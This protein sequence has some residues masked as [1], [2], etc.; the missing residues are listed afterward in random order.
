M[1]EVASL[2]IRT[3]ALRVEGPAELGLVLGVPAEGAELGHA[4]RKLALLAVFARA[5]LFESAAQLRLVA[6]GVAL[7]QP[8]KCYLVSF[9]GP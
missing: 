1:D 3:E 4:V 2:A 7:P 5:V 8:D 9:T 6:R